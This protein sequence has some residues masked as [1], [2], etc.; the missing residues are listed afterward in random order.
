GIEGKFIKTPSLS[1]TDKQAE[2]SFH[3]DRSLD[4]TLRDLA[5]RML[6]LCSSHSLIVRFIEERI[7]FKYGLVNH[8]LA[9]ALRGVLE[10]FYVFVGQLETQQN[11]GNLTLQTLWFHTEPVMHIM[12]VVAIIVR[13]INKGN[14]IGRSVLDLLHEQTQNSSGYKQTYDTCY[15]LAKSA[16]KPYLT[17]LETW[18]YKGI[19][20]DPYNEFMVTENKDVQKENLENDF[21][22]KYWGKRYVLNRNNTPRLLESM[23]EMILNTGKYLNAIRES[24]ID[25]K[26]KTMEELKYTTKEKDL[27]EPLEKAYQYASQ[28]LLNLVLNEYHLLERFKT[29]KH[30]FLIDQGDYIVQFMDIAEDEL[31]KSASIINAEKIDA[32]LVVALGTSIDPYK[33]D[34]RI[35]LFNYDL[36]S[37]LEKVITIDRVSGGGGN[38]S[39]SSSSSSVSLYA[40]GD[41]ASTPKTSDPIE[42][43]L[44]GLE[45]FSLDY[46]VKWPISLIIN[47]F[48]LVRYQMLFRYLFYVKHIERLLCNVWRFHKNGRKLTTRQQQKTTSSTTARKTNVG[49]AAA[50]LRHK[51]LHFVQNLLYYMSF[52]V[53]EPHWHT[54]QTNLKKVTNIDELLKYHFLFLDNCLRD[55]MLTNGHLLRLIHKLMA[56]CVLFANTMMKVDEPIPFSSTTTTKTNLPTSEESLFA[57][58]YN[59]NSNFTN[60]L[61]ALLDA[62]SREDG[63][64]HG[65]EHRLT[66]I[67]HR[68]NF[69]NQ[70]HFHGG[71]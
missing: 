60:Q 68:I 3:I 10:R 1:L 70:Y 8:A 47:R 50:Y 18:I 22:D 23:S 4:P 24:G 34:L 19:I 43:K 7:Q 51:M 16:F 59:F 27:E 14:N 56:I 53:I 57:M 66:N 67:I 65:Q 30:Y 9:G 37:M 71:M 6:P 35:K 63:G 58:I 41:F 49:D 26:T 64:V 48:V 15:Y 25:D 45:S 42:I 2:R 36:I 40:Q 61:T 5:R 54:F 69:N 46:D 31:N 55:C 44:S 28:I 17:M 52:E 13:T 29:L 12:E 38:S 33:D 32:L 39:L 21:N 62:I 20:H 11:L